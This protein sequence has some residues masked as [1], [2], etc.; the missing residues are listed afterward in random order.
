MLIACKTCADKYACQWCPYKH[1]RYDIKY[2][3]DTKEET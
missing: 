1:D 3:E 2:T